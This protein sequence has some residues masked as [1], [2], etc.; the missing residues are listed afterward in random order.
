MT[1]V[2][3]PELDESQAIT[4][5]MARWTELVSNPVGSTD[6][7]NPDTSTHNKSTEDNDT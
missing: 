7:Q 6:M 2:T 4:P 5:L 3:V 1:T